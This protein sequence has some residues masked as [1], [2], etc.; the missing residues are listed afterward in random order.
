MCGDNTNPDTDIT[1]Y[2]NTYGNSDINTYTNI[3]T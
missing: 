3:R 2:R 1:T